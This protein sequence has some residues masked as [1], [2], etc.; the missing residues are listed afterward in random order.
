M[1]QTRLNSKIKGQFYIPAVKRIIANFELNNIRLLARFPSYLYFSD[2]TLRLEWT[3]N[4]GIT[5][6]K[7]SEGIL[8]G[9]EMSHPDDPIQKE[10]SP[11]WIPILDNYMPTS[12]EDALLELQ[13]KGILLK[14]DL[15]E[16]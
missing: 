12:V 8:R 2:S 6:A 11:G 16:D 5:A 15:D 14:T 3:I 9:H 10:D 1:K 4:E 7:W 13:S